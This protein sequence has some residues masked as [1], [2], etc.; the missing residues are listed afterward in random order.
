MRTILG[1]MLREMGFE[2]SEAV[3]GCD[4]LERLKAQSPPALALLDWNMPEMNG[5]ELLG[6]LRADR[7]YDEMRIVM[8]TT[9]TEMSQMVRALETGANEYVMKPFTRDVMREKLQLLGILEAKQ[10]HS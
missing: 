2:V 8:V 1:G 3:N 10:E 4:A 9:E 5:I 7:I 6:K